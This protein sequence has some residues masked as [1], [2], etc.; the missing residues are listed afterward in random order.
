MV[1]GT[2]M[3]VYTETTMRL[4]PC[5]NCIGKYIFSNYFRIGRLTTIYLA[6]SLILR[7]PIVCVFFIIPFK[8]PWILFIVIVCLNARLYKQKYLNYFEE[9]SFS[10]LIY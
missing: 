2:P 5:F 4:W 9:E 7:L 6:E 3:L 10:S 8:L 1:T